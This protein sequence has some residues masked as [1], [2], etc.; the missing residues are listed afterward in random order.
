M[1][2]RLN[3]AP[4]AKTSG[5]RL[6]RRDLLKGGALILSAAFIP[7]KLAAAVRADESLSVTAWVRIGA[8]NAVTLIA[9]QSEMGQ[10]TTTTLAAVLADELFLP[11]ERVAIAFASFDPAYRDPVFHWMFTGNSQSTSSFYAI[12]R[13]MGAAAREMLVAAAAARWGV[14]AEK[15]TLDNAHLAHPDGRRRLTFGAV[16]ADAARLPVPAK[17]ILRAD[18]PSAGR[19]LR[20][21]DIP[22]KVDGSAQFGIDVRLSDMVIAAVR[23]APRRGARL[24]TYDRASIRAKP[25]VVDVVEIPGG[26]AVVA[27]T[28]WQARQALD[29]ASLTWSDAGDGLTSGSRLAP[30]YAERMASG[31]FFTH[32]AK[33]EASGGAAGAA[34]VE[35]TYQ[36]PF[37]A[38]AT[39][40]P[41]NC[42][43]R[44]SDGACEIWAPSQGVEMA[45]NVAVQVTGLPS[46]KIVIH[47]TLIGGGFGRRLLADFVKQTLLVAMAVKRPVKLIWSR[48]EDMTHDFYR[49]AALHRISGTLDASGAL[50]AL[51]HRVVTP[52][53]MLYIIPRGFLPPMKDWTDPAA[54]P[55]KIDT[56]AVEGLIELPYAIASQRVEQHRLETDIP[57]SVWRTTGHG[58]NNFA[59]ESFIEE[60]AAAAKRDPVAFRRALLGSD[61]RALGVLD[62]V[63]KES[64]WASPVRDGASRGVALAK[65]F[66]GY[67]A[68]V[69]EVVV[70]DDKVRVRRLTFAIDCGRLLDPGIAASNIEGG[71]V[72]GLS[73]MRTEVTFER[74]S[75]VQTNF[76]AFEPLRIYEMPV[77][78]V[79]FVASEET[80]GGTGEL[81]PVPVHA[82][83]GNA[84]A[85]AT[86][87]R[88]RTLP[89]ASAGLSFA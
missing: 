53:H 66:G 27:R 3:T 30:V 37:Q 84:I 82:A 86:G 89:L 59:V 11:P 87:R 9:S 25:G 40:E 69:A 79:H 58:P 83:V 78:D 19:A 18:P 70:R 23:C 20:R 50:V 73:G 10:G 51:D 2:A 54:P 81:G 32:L 44:I 64:G 49:P 55:E 48:E 71:A 13:Q 33:V 41:M 21:W 57:V 8:D 75:A 56:M 68:A 45:Q 4:R 52:S 46:E 31:P 29:G 24:A 62:L 88:V 26:L 14:P 5:H 28:Y 60:L 80:P 61:K 77:I 16:A 22:G 47:R 34:T 35:A 15:I 72:W 17:P 36:T 7:D 74:G 43:A 38:H 67:V 1:H 65:A 76:D 42:T 39:M 85:A 12:M 63:A 6:A